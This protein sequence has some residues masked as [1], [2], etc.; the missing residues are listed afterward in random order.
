MSDLPDNPVMDKDIALLFCKACHWTHQAWVMHKYL[1]DQNNKEADTLEKAR[2]FTI[3]L[4]TITQEYSL[5]Q[6]GSANC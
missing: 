5:Q 2:A 6:I 4:S 3:R 1:F